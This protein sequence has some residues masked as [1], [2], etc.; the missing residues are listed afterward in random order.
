MPAPIAELC[1]KQPT[2]HSGYNPMVH[3]DRIEG[4]SGKHSWELDG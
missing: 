1:W 3:C 2:L 4:H